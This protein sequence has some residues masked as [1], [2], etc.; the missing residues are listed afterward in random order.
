MA[1]PCPPPLCTQARRYPRAEKSGFQEKLEFGFGEYHDE[2]RNLT[3]KLSGWIQSTGCH[4]AMSSLEIK[5]RFRQ[6]CVQIL[7]LPLGSSV[8]LDKSLD[9][10]GP[11]LFSRVNV[12]LWRLL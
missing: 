6:T 9:F 1:T 7:A 5:C 2:T 3:H 12:A 10:A 8:T 4:F 11:H